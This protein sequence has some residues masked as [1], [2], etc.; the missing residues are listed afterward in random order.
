MYTL[1]HL[2][3]NHL[4]IEGGLRYNLFKHTIPNDDPFL[5]DGKK[6]LVSP[7][8][9]VAN[10]AGVYVIAPCHSIHI[11]YSSGYRAPN[12]DDLGTLGLVDFRYE[13]PAYDLRPEKSHNTELGY[14]WSARHLKLDFSLFNMRL[15]D[16]ISRRRLD[17]QQVNGYNVYIKENSQNSFIRGFEFS[18]DYQITNHL[19]FK[20]AS[21]YTYGQNQS[22]GEPMR[23]IPPLFGRNLISYQKA[24]FS[25]TAEHLYAGKQDRLAQGDIDDN[26]IP[27]GGT[28]GW[29]VL[30]IYS[31]YLITNGLRLRIGLQNLLNA[32]YRYHG[33]GING[34]GRSAWLAVEVEI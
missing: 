14:R 4:L 8:S 25:I 31:D 34:V 11:S 22:V 32:D 33:S 27:S 7:S 1:H 17:D 20:T 6:I 24:K 16:L 13:I 10:L 21:T 2:E 5:A 30:N 15:T 12:I 29:S 23:R 18:F 28:P 3:F 19:L 9:L 26:R